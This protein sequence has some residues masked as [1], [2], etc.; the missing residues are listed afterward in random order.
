MSKRKWLAGVAL[1]AGLS[2]TPIGWRNAIASA[3]AQPRV[4]Q[5]TA[6]KFQFS[7]NEIDLNKGEP[8]VIEL[9]S[10]DTTH[11][12][13]VRPLKIDTDI[14]PGQMTRIEVTPQ[15]A[16]TFKAI[17]DHYCGLGHGNMKLT[18]VVK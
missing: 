3:S 18:I 6:E 14:K 10:K 5:I 17:C 12:F 11:G 16:G 9:S 2:F 15:S 7:P 1:M 4:V 8:V 13:M